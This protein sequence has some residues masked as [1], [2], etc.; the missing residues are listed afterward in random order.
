MFPVFFI[1]FLVLYFMQFC[2]VNSFHVPDFFYAYFSS[3]FSKLFI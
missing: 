3:F 1:D 2:P